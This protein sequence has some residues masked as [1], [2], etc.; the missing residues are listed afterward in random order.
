MS[1]FIKACPVWEKEKET[2]MNY[3]LS[4]RLICKKSEEILLKIA[5]SCNYRIW[6]NGVFVA[7]GP[8]R[9]AK[10]IYKVDTIDLQSWMVNAENVIVID[11]SAANINNF[12][13]LEQPAFVTAEV[14]S[15]GKCIAWTGTH[16]NIACYHTNARVQKTQKYTVQ[17]TFTEVWRYCEKLKKFYREPDFSMEM[18]NIRLCELE[19]AADGV[20]VKRDIRYPNYVWSEACKVVESG[21]ID[22]DQKCEKI[23]RP[24]AYVNIGKNMKGFYPEELEEK[25]SDEVQNFVSY[26]KKKGI[27][28]NIGKIENG[29][30]I[31]EQS[32]DMSGFIKIKVECKK[33]CVIYILFDEVLTD[34][35]VDFLRMTTCSCVKY[36]LDKGTYELQTFEPYTMKY[37]KIIVKGEAKLE[38]A[39][40]M[41]YKH[42]APLFKVKLPSDT[43][44][45]KIYQAAVETYQANAVDN[46]YDCP[47]RERAGWLCD[48]FFMGR[49]E[50]TLTGESVLEKAFLENFIK[51][52]TFPNIPEGMLPMCYPADFGDGN[53][54]PQWAMWYVLEL[55]EYYDR[56]GDKTL[57]ESAKTRIYRL[58]TYFEKFVNKNGLLE[59]LDGWN[60]VEW[61]KANDWIDGVSFPTNMLYAKMLQA[62]GNLYQDKILLEKSSIVKEIVRERSYNGEFFTD[63]ELVEKDGYKNPQHCSEVCQYYAFFTETATPKDYPKLWNTLLEEF[64]PKRAETGKYQEIAE[65]APFIG[66]Y[67]RLEILYCEKKYDILI[68]NIKTYF[69][70]MA[71][72]TGTI[73]EAYHHGNSRCHGFASHLVYWLAGIYGLE[74]NDL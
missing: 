30:V 12:Y 16:G 7:F 20:Y 11:A 4:F 45:E 51:A 57:V 40:V 53:F 68:E 72:Q 65:S 39:G 46:Y 47:S 1:E 33:S 63:H 69:A 42:E 60:F 19:A 52:E 23:C 14:I 8:A 71:Q 49:A 37:L 2:E 66:N 44:L 70:D 41:Q 38:Y 56:S 10:G 32:F 6:V 22:F 50:K 58:L 64:G 9:A 21:K 35:D 73:W 54:I 67:L 17:R 3:E 31:L 34:G 27:F 61:S 55:E 15:E 36:Y 48:S 62:A 25:L 24:S 59:N 43:L 13:V 29:Y 28:S 74:K 5:T 18:S 26:D